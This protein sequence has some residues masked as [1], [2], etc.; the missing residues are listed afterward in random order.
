MKTNSKSVAPG[1]HSVTPYLIVKGAVDAMEFYKR[2]FGAATSMEPLMLPDGRV[3]HAEMT[4]GDSVIML[5]DE[6]PEMDAK[7]PASHGGSP[8]SL[9]LYVDE[10]DKVA[11]QV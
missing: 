9:H 11:K 5:A 10:V 6:S 7:G 3:G 4:I 8:V 2:A 1:R